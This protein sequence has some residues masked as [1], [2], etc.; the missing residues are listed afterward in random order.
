MNTR[1]NWTDTENAALVALYFRMLNHAING[2]KYNKAAM[3]RAVQASEL[4]TRSRGSIEAKLMNVSAV[5]RDLCG[6]DETMNQYGYKYAPNYQASL[7]D[8]F[9][10][11][12]TVMAFRQAA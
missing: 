9:K 2:E 10:Q 3:I 5:H 1:R 11:H 8:A 4:L 6:T 7:K 12:V